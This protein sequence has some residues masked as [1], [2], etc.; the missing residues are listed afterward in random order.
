MIQVTKPK[1]ALFFS[2][3]QPKLD[4]FLI[5]SEYFPLSS[6][7]WMVP[8]LRLP[9]LSPM[10]SFVMLQCS[11]NKLSPL[12]L[13]VHLF[14]VSEPSSCHKTYSR[15][16][17]FIRPFQSILNRLS[18]L[19]YFDVSFLTDFC[20]LLTKPSLQVLSRHPF[21]IHTPFHEHLQR[22]Y[23]TPPHTG[24]QRYLALPNNLTIRVHGYLEHGW[25]NQPH[26]K[27]S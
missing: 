26:K 16:Y 5:L 27:R 18:F 13:K 15:Y 19:G 22:T 11:Q 4:L 14:P 9:I 20:K 6:L 12:S 25:L 8:G 7:A 17:V 21:F 1:V 24:H 23:G 3:Q 10:V 2:R